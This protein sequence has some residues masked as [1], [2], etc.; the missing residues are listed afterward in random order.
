MGWEAERRDWKGSSGHARCSF[1]ISVLELSGRQ[2][3][4]ALLSTGFW[5]CGEQGQ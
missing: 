3:S 5:M 2:V 1:I 4:A